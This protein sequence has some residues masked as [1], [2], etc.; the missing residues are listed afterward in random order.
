MDDKLNAWLNP[1]NEL[2]QKI[3]VNYSRFFERL[4]CAGNIELKVP[5]DK[6]YKQ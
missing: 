6:V 2:I 5:D 4:G 3:N 1:L